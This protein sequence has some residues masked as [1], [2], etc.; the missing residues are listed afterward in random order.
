VLLEDRSKKVYAPVANEG[1]KER[2]P[3]QFGSHKL[4][5][6]DSIGQKFNI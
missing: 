6:D 4:V 3:A 5:R 2:Q 1:E